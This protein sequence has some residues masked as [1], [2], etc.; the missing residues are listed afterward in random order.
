ME[1]SA[2]LN[3]QVTEIFSTIGEWWG[4]Q[5]S[6]AG[7]DGG[8][9]ESSLPLLLGSPFWRPGTRQNVSGGWKASRIAR[10]LD[11]MALGNRQGGRGPGTALRAGCMPGRG[12][13]LPDHPPL[14]FTAQELLQREDRKKAQPQRGDAGLALKGPPAG[15]AGCCAH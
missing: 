9:G 6:R 5:G 10:G 12:P 1:A 8:G 13:P 15:Q 11:F 3:H 7:G 14:S 2:K 4:P